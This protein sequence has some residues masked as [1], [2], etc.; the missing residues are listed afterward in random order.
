LDCGKNFYSYVFPSMNMN[1]PRFSFNEH[2]PANGVALF[3]SGLPESL[4]EPQAHNG[5]GCVVCTV[6][7]RAKALHLCTCRAITGCMHGRQAEL[8]LG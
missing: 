2:E 7:C 3:S 8:E 4:A 6:L 5:D 1:Q